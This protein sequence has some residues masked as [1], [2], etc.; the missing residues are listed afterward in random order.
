[1][2]RMTP[3]DAKYLNTVSLRDRAAILKVYLKNNLNQKEIAIKVFH[4]YDDWASMSVS[5]VTRSFGFH[6]GRGKGRY[7]NIPDHVIDQFVQDY[8]PVDYDEG[9]DE[10]TFDYYIKSYLQEIEQQRQQAAQQRLWQQQQEEAQ[11]KRQAE[12]ARQQAEWAAQQERERQRREAERKQREEAER[13]EQ[14]RLEREKQ[15]KE[16]QR[17]AAVERG[18]HMTLMNEAMAALK[19]HNF[20]LARAKA[21]QAWDMHPMVGLQ[22]V[23]AYC[24]DAEGDRANAAEWS[25]EASKGYQEGCDQYF[26][27][28]VLHIKNRGPNDTTATRKIVEHSKMTLLGE[29]TIAF[30]MD[31]LFNA[32]FEFEGGTSTKKEWVSDESLI[33]LER[34]ANVVAFR[35]YPVSN[36]LKMQLKCAFA[37]TY[38][39]YYTMARDIYWEL[40]KHV[41]SRVLFGGHGNDYDLEINLGKCLYELEDYEG[42]INAW[43]PASEYT[44]SYVTRPLE[45]GMYYGY[46]ENMLDVSDNHPEVQRE[47]ELADAY[48]NGRI[49]GSQYFSRF[50][51]SDWQDVLG[52]S[53]EADIRWIVNRFDQ[54]ELEAFIPK[55]K[56]F[57]GRLFGR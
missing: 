27:M 56:G 8:D 33:A 43:F 45:A 54:W 21:E 44:D 42:A 2:G 9:L 37:L 3:N 38:F 50:Y 53:P 39:G 41:D 19:A 48:R 18:D 6:E 47:L 34:L 10:G 16:A 20:E 17:K 1:M 36:N 5:S 32:V 14:L 22:Y 4:N 31:A 52:L 13:R 24:F 35:D 49:T 11:K 55:A 26:D 29:D 46:G 51:G 23:L 25:W 7:R 30:A 12:L 15:A 40:E 28:L 57:F